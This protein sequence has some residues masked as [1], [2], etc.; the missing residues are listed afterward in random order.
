MTHKWNSLETDVLV[1]GGGVA[2]CMAAI[3]ALEA[4]LSVVVCEKGTVLDHCGSVGCGVDHYLTI[5]ESGPEWRWT[6]NPYFRRMNEP[7]R[8][9]LYSWGSNNEYPIEY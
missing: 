2:G 5:M 3:P 9:L 7:S 6:P 1:I 8:G 4:G